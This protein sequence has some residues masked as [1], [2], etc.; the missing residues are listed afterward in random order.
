MSMVWL[1]IIVGVA[2]VA[3]GG[4]ITYFVARHF[5]RRP[6]KSEFT[7]TALTTFIEETDIT[8]KSM[9][10]QVGAKGDLQNVNIPEIVEVVR[11]VV[12]REVDEE[13][14]SGGAEEEET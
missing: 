10:F 5:Q 9:Q 8:S 2:G 11:Q 6:Q 13:D 12:A 4:I 14:K 3:L 7:V 1:T